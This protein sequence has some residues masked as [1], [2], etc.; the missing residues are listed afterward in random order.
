MAAD[1]VDRLALP[2][3]RSSATR[4]LRLHGA[5]GPRPRD[6]S[7]HLW[8]RYGTDAVAVLALSR[9]DAALAEPLVPG[10]PYLAAEAIWA[11]RAEMAMTLDD[12]LSRR[13]RALILDRAGVIRAAPA[14]AR[15]LAPEFGWS[16][17]DQAREVTAFTA[18]A[19][20]G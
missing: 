6:L 18:T 17:D 9:T 20:A 10:L 12:V 7:D 1:T 14:V 8:A 16:E 11:V 15:L 13:L 4:R 2:G 3:L 19:H 5:A